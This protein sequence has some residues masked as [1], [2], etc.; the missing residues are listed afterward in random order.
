MKRRFR[1]TVKL[2]KA[3]SSVRLSATLVL[4]CFPA[5]AQTAAEVKGKKIV[6]DAIQ[7]LGG[8]KF[9]TMEDRTEHGRAFSYYRDQISGL[10]IASIYT[11]YITVAPDRTGVD[12]AQREREAFGKD[13]DSFV[14]FTEKG[15]WSVTYHG[16]HEM[17]PDQLARYK[18]TTLRN[19]FYI[20]RVR[21]NEPGMV[22]ESRGSDVVENQPA[23][24]VDITDSDDRMVTV[25]FNQTTH[26]PIRQSYA[27]VNQLYHDQDQEVTLFSRYQDSNGIEWPH[28]IHRERNGDKIYEMFS[29]TVKFNTDLTDDLFSVPEPGTASAKKKHKK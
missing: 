25:A 26:L 14:L 22:F 15:G 27:H 1:S 6:D 8:Q 2:Q 29:D 4:L 20:L 5:L 18:E 11:R 10:D 13:E 12:V 9:L 28:E 21:L 17:E 7:A 24:L 16:A 19:I 23:D 3:R